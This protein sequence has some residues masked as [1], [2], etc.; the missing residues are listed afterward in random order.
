MIRDCTKGSSNE[1]ER[2]LSRK[3]E[4][5]REENVLEFTMGCFIWWFIEN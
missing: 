5:E 1:P 3:C 4:E 2:D